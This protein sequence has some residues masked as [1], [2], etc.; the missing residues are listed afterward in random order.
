MEPVYFDD[1]T[2]VY[3]GDARKFD[4][5]DE[6]VDAVICDPPYELGFMGKAHDSTGIAY[7][8]ALWRNILRV[9]KPGGHLL[10]FG[11]TRTYH[12]MTVAIE[13]AGFEIRDSLMW[14]YG[15]GYPKSH[16]VSK[17]I[18]K[19]AGHH[20]G[21]AGPLVSGNDA[22]SGGNYKR[23]EKGPP[24]TADAITWDGWGTALKPAFEPI[25]CAR[26]PFSGTVVTN[27]LTHG[28]GAL[29]INGCRVGTDARSNPAAGNKPGSAALHMSAVG[30]P[31][32]VAAR[33]TTS[34]W[35][36][37]VVFTHNEECTDTCVSGCPV[38]ELDEQTGVTTSTK[39]TGKRTGKRAGILG[40]FTGQESVTM[41]HDDTGGASRFF[42]TFR[43]QAK[44]PASERPKVD[45]VAHSTVK[46][47]DLMRWLCRLVTPP[48][49]IILDWCAG[50]GAT[51]EAARLEGFRSIAVEA[52]ET[53]IP[54]IM[55][56][57]KRSV[58][59]SSS[60]DLGS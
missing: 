29:N 20:R 55:E 28:T 14:M 19:A 32:G 40:E 59:Q 39:R 50:S 6:S 38:R 43:Y 45:G 4:R 36:A 44:A 48:N 49:G 33:E 27:V 47:L 56:R 34:R 41:G 60:T 7:D 12:R 3:H 8:V 54:L 15:S 57:I 1:R 53:Y 18:D 26:K 17:A 16:D 13:D 23:T 31:Q 22:M 24:I 35:P 10:A 5:P 11:G 37:N 30:M 25:T 58:V 52:E 51:I 46:P 42:P 21:A 9:L 2:I